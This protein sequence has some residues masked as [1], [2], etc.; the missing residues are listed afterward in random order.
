MGERPFP[1]S[2]GV[3]CFRHAWCRRAAAPP[4]DAPM[5]ANGHISHL[6]QQP[7]EHKQLCL[8]PQ[9]I[10]LTIA[11]AFMFGKGSLVISAQAV[12]IHLNSFFFFFF[13]LTVN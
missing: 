5:G 8:P 4:P 9:P 2:P 1:V 3:L 12:E 6:R 11:A 10:V 7:C 13:F